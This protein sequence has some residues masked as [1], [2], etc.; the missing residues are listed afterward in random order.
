V[1]ARFGA[2]LAGKKFALWGL[3]FKAKTNDMRESATIDIVK[4]LSAHGAEIV[5]YDSLAVE[6]AQNVYL[7]EFSGVTYEKFDKY[8]ILEGCDALVIA[9]ETGEYR[10]IDM[11]MVKSAL[12]NPVIFDGRNLLD[13]PTLKKSGF[14]YYAIGRGDKLDWQDIRLCLEK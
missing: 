9:T 3:S 1:V 10:T 7:K 4:H 5:A 2:D 6:E 14:E 13:I 8:K 12:K 11:D